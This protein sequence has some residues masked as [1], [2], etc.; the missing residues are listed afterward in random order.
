MVTERRCVGHFN[1]L[2]RALS[3]QRLANGAN[4]PTGAV[5]GLWTRIKELQLDDEK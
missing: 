5:E 2:L 3:A 4:A 1:D